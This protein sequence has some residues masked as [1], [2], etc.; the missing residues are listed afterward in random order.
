MTRSR[1]FMVLCSGAVAAAAVVLALRSRPQS[2]GKADRPGRLGLNDVATTR[3]Y[4]ERVERLTVFRVTVDGE[5]ITRGKA[6]DFDPGGVPVLR[7]DLEVE[8]RH[9]TVWVRDP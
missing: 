1:T 2:E 8:G 9:V 5:A 3:I 7:V 4:P 6:A